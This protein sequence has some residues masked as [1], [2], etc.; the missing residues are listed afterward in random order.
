DPFKDTSGPSMNILIKLTCLIGLVI[1]PILGGHTAD[2]SHE[3]HDS[4]N[5]T[6]VSADMNTK[7]NGESNETATT[8]VAGTMDLTKMSDETLLSLERD[9]INIE[10]MVS[11]ERFEGLADA[12]AS[13]VKIV[14]D[15]VE[16]DRPGLI[17][18]TIN[19]IKE[20]RAERK[21]EKDAEDN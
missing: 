7:N 12:R 11:R 10:K 20:K 8:A 17:K 6:E 1:A 2:A 5:H 9:G 18:R 21:A 3:G 15:T 13:Y 4:M 19:N 16:V 14:R